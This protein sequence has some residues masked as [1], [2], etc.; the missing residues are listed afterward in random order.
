MFVIKQNVR[1]FE[2][3]VRNFEENV[4]N[5]EI[6]S[7]SLVLRTKNNCRLCLTW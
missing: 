5:F 3:N 2:E 7:V 1:N 4:R 6:F